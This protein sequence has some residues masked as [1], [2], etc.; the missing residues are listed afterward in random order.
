MNRTLLV[1]GSEEWKN[2]RKF[3]ACASEMGALLGI[4]TNKSRAACLKEKAGTSSP[5]LSATAERM[6][7]L[8]KAYEPVAI[9]QAQQFFPYPLMDLGSLRFNKEKCHDFEGRPDAVTIDPSSGHWI[10][11]EIKTRAYP[12]PFDSVPYESVYDVPLKHWVQ[13]QCYMLLLDSPY[14]YLVSF[15]PNH[16]MR[17]FSQSFSPDLANLIKLYVCKFNT[18]MLSKRVDSREKK[19]VLA[20][21]DR[22]I[23]QKTQEEM[24][25]EALNISVLNK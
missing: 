10:P 2:A 13:L 6:C 9:Y 11:L 21:I 23:R 8:G 20:V 25:V 15:S 16:G 18:N 19:D 22:L 17:L 7:D 1:H 3:T 5:V 12:N 14:G 24:F 4:D